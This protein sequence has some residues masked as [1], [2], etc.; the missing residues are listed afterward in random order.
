MAGVKLAADARARLKL[1]VGFYR[2]YYS[3]DTIDRDI[4]IDW[5]ISHFA[6]LDHDVVWN[7]KNYALQCRACRFVAV[8]AAT[9]NRHI[10]EG[11]EP[12]GLTLDIQARAA[13]NEARNGHSGVETRAEAGD[14]STLDIDEGTEAAPVPHDRVPAEPAVAASL[15]G[16]LS[17][18]SDR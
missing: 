1:L 2:G 9:M 4:V 17:P 6:P 15:E 14:E 7:G 5:A 18:E 16:Q 13:A 3:N 12:S 11:C 8:R 10:R